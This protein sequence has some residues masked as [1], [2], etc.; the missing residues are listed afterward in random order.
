MF[1]RVGLSAMAG[2]ACAAGLLAFGVLASASA[3]TRAPDAV[4]KDVATGF[5]LDSNANKQAYTHDCNGGSYQKWTVSNGTTLKDLATGFCLDSNANKQVYTHDCNGG[6]Y[7]KWT[8]GKSARGTTLKNL[9]TGF[10]LD[11]NANRQLYTHD[12]NGGSYQQWTGI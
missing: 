12:C 3:E 4:V 6:S 9:A 5:C 11:S 1:S 7:Q 2:A 10:C 8:L